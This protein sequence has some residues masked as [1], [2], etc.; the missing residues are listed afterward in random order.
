MK[1]IPTK[2]QTVNAQTG[3]VEK[4]EFVP[5]QVMPPRSG[6][7]AICATDHRPEEPHNAQ[8]LYWSVVFNA[9]TG[10]APTWADAIAHCAKPMQA[11]WK[12]ELKKRKAWTEPPKGC[13]PVCLP[14][15]K[16]P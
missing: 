7:C 15:S 2:M 14:Y 4:T 6:L 12:G 11:A 16:Q 9:E 1:S 13:A 8:S 3:K 5:M 10:R